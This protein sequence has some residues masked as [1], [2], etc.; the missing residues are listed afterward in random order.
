VKEP[1]AFDSGL[2]VTSS[3]EVPGFVDGFVS[4]SAVQ[5][6][7]PSALEY[8]LMPSEPNCPVYGHNGPDQ[9]V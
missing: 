5:I 1:G 3:A 6:L 7:Y 8:C 4:Q 2:T 9:S